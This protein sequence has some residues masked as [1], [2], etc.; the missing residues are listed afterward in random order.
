MFVD[1][2]LIIHNKCIILKLNFAILPKM[3]IFVCYCSQRIK[4]TLFGWK[5]LLRMRLKIFIAT[6]LIGWAPHSAIAQLDLDKIFWDQKQ[7]TILS[8]IQLVASYKNLN[9]KSFLFRNNETS[10]LFVIDESR[11][12]KLNN[13]VL[14]I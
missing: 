5:M 9:S 2:R 13:Q 1:P 11:Y 7:T 3:L 6:I 14:S 8:E 4:L 12:F 10:E